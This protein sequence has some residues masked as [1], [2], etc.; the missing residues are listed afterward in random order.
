M[1]Q[2]RIDGRTICGRFRAF[3]WTPLLKNPPIL[4]LR[5]AEV[6]KGEYEDPIKT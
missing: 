1:K 3:A 6:Y 5:A 2:E 4:S